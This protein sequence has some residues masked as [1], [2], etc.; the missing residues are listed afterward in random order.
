MHYDSTCK[1]T[2]AA[3]SLFAMIAYALLQSVSS[4]MLRGLSRGLS[5]FP[6]GSP[7]IFVRMRRDRLAETTIAAGSPS[8]GCS[9]LA[10]PRE[11]RTGL[12][13]FTLCTA[14]G[15]STIVPRGASDVRALHSCTEH[16][17][18]AEHSSTCY[19]R[20]DKNC[21]ISMDRRTP[22]TSTAYEYSNLSA[23]VLPVLLESCSSRALVDFSRAENEKEE[24]QKDHTVH[25]SDASLLFLPQLV[26]L[27]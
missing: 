10:R 9:K 6:I 22:S 15:G 18:A 23:A 1:S 16:N 11:S 26:R 19:N 17:A 25:C 20:N 24:A 13:G 4:E 8:S 7:H 2:D 14:C 3:A 5:D 12:S 27:S 21:R